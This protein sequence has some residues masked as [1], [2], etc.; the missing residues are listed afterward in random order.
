MFFGRKARVP[1]LFAGRLS[2]YFGAIVNFVP[3]RAA[4]FLNS[5]EQVA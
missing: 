3:A 5:S 1:H 2:T 4:A